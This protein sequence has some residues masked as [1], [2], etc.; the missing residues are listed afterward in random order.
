MQGWGGGIHAHIWFHLFFTL[1]VKHYCVTCVYCVLILTT[2]TKNPATFLLSIQTLISPEPNHAALRLT[3]LNMNEKY[4]I[5]SRDIFCCSGWRDCFLFF[6]HYNDHMVMTAGPKHVYRWSTTNTWT[7]M[8]DLIEL[9]CGILVDFPGG[10]CHLPHLSLEHLCL[11]P[12]FSFATFPSTALLPS[13]SHFPLN[14]PPCIHLSILH[15]HL[16]FQ[17]LSLFSINSSWESSLFLFSHAFGNWTFF[18]LSN[19]P[20]PCCFVT[21]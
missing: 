4:H 3:Q 2:T 16:F 17:V 20:P 7:E 10:L 12:C 13:T 19:P 21:I 1:L 9:Y 6:L 5:Q 8:Q 18:S 11:I 15:H 14:F